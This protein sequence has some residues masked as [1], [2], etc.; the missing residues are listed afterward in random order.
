[1]TVKIWDVHMDSKPF[2]V[3]NV[4]EHIR[5]HL[6]ELYSIDTIFDKFDVCCSPDGQQFVTGTY[7]YITSIA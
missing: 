4:H 5:P 6:Q 7:R 1:M 3:V 2:K